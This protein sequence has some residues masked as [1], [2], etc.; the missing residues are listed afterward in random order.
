MFL[1][2]NCIIFTFILS[3]ICAIRVP[4]HAS[5][6]SKSV[7]NSRAFFAPFRVFRSKI[8]SPP[9]SG[10]FVSI[11]VHSWLLFLSNTFSNRVYL[12]RSALKSGVKPPHSKNEQRQCGDSLC[13]LPVTAFRF[14]HH[15][16][17]FSRFS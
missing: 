3:P 7:V 16:S 2:N 12:E 15:F 4:R 17:R 11:R 13:N 1:S 10:P 6:S 9:R 14:P 5:G 8:L